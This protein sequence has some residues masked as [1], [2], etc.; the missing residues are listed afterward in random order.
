[1]IVITCMTILVLVIEIDMHNL[2]E[3]HIRGKF[4]QIKENT[5]RY[6]VHHF[7]VSLGVSPRQLVPPKN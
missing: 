6:F 5:G 3:S 4:F 2:K 7:Y 1:M